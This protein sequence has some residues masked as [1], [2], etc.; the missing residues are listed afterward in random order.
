MRF[1]RSRH[2]LVTVGAAFAM[3]VAGCGQSAESGASASGSTGTI[4]VDQ[5]LRERLPDSV[6]DRG[7]IQFATDPSYAPMESFAPD[8]QTVVGFDAD[9]AAALGAVLGIEIEMVPANFSTALDE[10]AK[11]EY[12][13]VLSALTDTVAREKKADFINYFS[14][15]TAIVV[16]RGN[17]TGVTDLKDLCGQPV[18]VEVSTVQEDLLKRSQKG[19][20][21]RPIDIRT[22]DT[23]SDALLQLRTGRAIA[24]LNDYPPAAQLANDPSSRTHYQLASTVQY[25][26]GLYGLAVPKSRPLPRAAAAL[27]AD[28]RRAPG[29]VDQRRRRWPGRL[30]GPAD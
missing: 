3:L 10:A 13:G 23:N 20:G 9:L 18:A 14:A 5:T 1:V 6:R 26:P 21:A 11:G 7:T 15:G 27:G 17:P 28:H 25:E 24:L 19:C 4:G 22:F 2:A 29:V 8:G 16:R 30:S 12:D